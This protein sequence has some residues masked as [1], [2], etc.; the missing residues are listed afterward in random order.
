MGIIN[1][2]RLGKAFSQRVNSL[3]KVTDRLEEAAAISQK[4][5]LAGDAET[6]KAKKARAFSD[7]SAQ[8]FPPNNTPVTG[9]GL[10]ERCLRLIFH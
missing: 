6:P 8:K 10:V 1:P 2:F 3:W 7:G 9:S 5:Q 4:R